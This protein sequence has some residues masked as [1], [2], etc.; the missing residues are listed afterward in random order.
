[1]PQ[2]LPHDTRIVFD[3]NGLLSAFVHKKFAGEVYE[4]CAEQYQLFTSE[5]ILD[6]LNEKLS[7]KF[8]LP[9]QLRQEIADRLRSDAQIAT[10]TNSM[11]TNSPDS[12]DNNVLRVALFV[13]AD[14][15]ITGDQKH[16][17]PLK[18]IAEMAIISPREFYERYIA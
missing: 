9:I 5:W 1:M 12:D 2:F 6:E 4:C 18:Q 15:L 3:T 16:L 11:P 14:F 8:K 7:N 13:N 17:L 10:P